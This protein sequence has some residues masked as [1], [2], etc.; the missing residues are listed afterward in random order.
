MTSFLSLKIRFPYIFN[1]INKITPENENKHKPQSTCHIVCKDTWCNNNNRRHVIA[2]GGVSILAFNYGL[3]LAWA[4]NEQEEKDESLVG[5]FKSLFDPNEKT[6]SGKVLPKAYLNSAR[7]V[8]KTLRESLNE[9]P[10][11]MAKFRRTADAA[12]ASIREYLGSWR[13]E[14]TVINEESYVV[15]VKAIRALASFYS[16]AGPSAP[17]PES[18]KSEIM[19]NLDTADKFL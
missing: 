9:D 3:P 11:D 12:K 16:K 18:V 17:L 10:N 2:S 8:V 6:K 4:E 7:E 19:S 15:I 1:S 14:K 5:A 13:G